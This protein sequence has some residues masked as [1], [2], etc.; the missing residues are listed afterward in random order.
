MIKDQIDKILTELNINGL[1]ED[2]KL[3]VVA[4]LTDHF[5]KIVLE[6]VLANLNDTQLQE[7]KEI[8]DSND[9]DKIDEGISLLVA[10]IPAIDLKLEE[11]VN[12]EIA[13]IKAS[14]AIMD[15]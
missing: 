12:A 6:T 9:P 14:K 5:N 7:F 13:H 4:Q 10:K 11:A 8:V 3:E 15:K 1:A 2:E